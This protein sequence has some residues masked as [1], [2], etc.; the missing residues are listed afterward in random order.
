MAE[1][2]RASFVLSLKDELS[3]G[4]RRIIAETKQLR[5]L[6]R[7]LGFKPLEG[8]SAIVNRVDRDVSQLNRDLGTTARQAENAAG[9]LRRMGAAELGRVREQANQVRQG[10]A[11]QRQVNAG[12]GI[13]QIYG[14]GGVPLFSGGPRFVPNAPGASSGVGLRGRLGNAFGRARAGFGAVQSQVGLVEGGLAGI[15]LEEPIRQ[16]AEFDNVLTHIAITAGATGDQVRVKVAEMAERYR[17]MALSVNQSSHDIAESAQFL[18]TTGIGEQVTNQ[19]LPIIA[20][21]ATAYNTPMQDAVQGA[22]SM[23]EELKIAPQD[24]AGALSAAALAAKQ[25]HFSF[26]DISQFL[27]SVAA[28]AATAGISGRE[29]LN[30]LLAALETSRRGAGTSGQAATNLQDFLGYINAPIGTKS[31]QKAGID[32]PGLLRN[33]EKQGINPMEAVIQRVKQLTAGMSEAQTASTLGKLFHNQEARIFV[34]TM[35][36]ELQYYED[37]KKKI[38]GASDQTI[39]ED[40]QKAQNLHTQLVTLAE[41]SSQ[42]NQKVGTGFSWVVPVGIALTGGLLAGLNWMDVHLPGVSSAV[43]G[44]TGGMLGLLAAMGVLGTIAKPVTLGFTLLRGAISSAFSASTLRLLVSPWLALPVLLGAAI[45]DI[46][47]H[48]DRFR[49]KFHAIADGIKKAMAGDFW[50]GTTQAWDATWGK[51]G[52]METLFTDFGAWVDGWSGGIA[53]KFGEIIQKSLGGWVKFFQDTKRMIEAAPEPSGARRDKDEP[54]APPAKK[55]PFVA[56]PYIFNEAYHPGAASG[57]PRTVHIH[58]TSDTPGRATLRDPSGAAT[59]RGPML[60]RA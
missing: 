53:T 7:S 33:A 57:A 49:D 43:L 22:F 17:S 35:L 45:Y 41:Q 27:P 55:E 13:G 40:F 4:L 46:A 52:V 44:L 38:S 8:A 36:R 31:F 9:A 24:M 60:T 10:L 47:E 32:L 59:A 56:P 39:N 14:P 42:L 37:T 11:V 16:A 51:G 30:S 50:A 21:A 20:R 1:S 23:H 6:A 3:S 58:F 19:L 54:A 15:S 34:E 18:I 28:Q 29:G 26:S 25:G 5:D 12:A 48:W 2:F